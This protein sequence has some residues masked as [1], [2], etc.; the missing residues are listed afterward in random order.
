MTKE[1]Y[2]HIYMFSPSVCVYLGHIVTIHV[3]IFLD[4]VT[5]N[6]ITNKTILPKDREQGGM[7][8][9]SSRVQCGFELPEGRRR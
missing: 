3:Y 8:F 5:L 6:K 9:Q 4:G 7:I 1:K 2:H